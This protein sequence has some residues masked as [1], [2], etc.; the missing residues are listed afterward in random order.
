MDSEGTFLPY[1]YSYSYLYSYLYRRG[2]AY[3]DD[4]MKLMQRLIDQRNR[5]LFLFGTRFD[6]YLSE[7]E[8]IFF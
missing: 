3:V 4:E 6:F 2:Q 5:Y 1:S 7:A 8:P